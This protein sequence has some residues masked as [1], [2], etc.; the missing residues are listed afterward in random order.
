MEPIDSNVKFRLLDLLKSL[1]F[2]TTSAED[3]T[4]TVDLDQSRVG[5][6]SRIDALQNQAIS[7]S[8]VAN[9]MIQI[10]EVKV[11]LE[12]LKN[13]EYGLCEACDEPINPKRLEHN[14]AARLCIVCASEA[15]QN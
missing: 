9:R 11:A 1:E 7:Q 2:A 3:T 13:N 5:R 8:A 6:L 12:R 4:A 14:P 10:V 15:E